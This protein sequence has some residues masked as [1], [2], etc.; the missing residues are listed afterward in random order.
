M[1]APRA[2]GI[3]PGAARLLRAERVGTVEIAHR[4]GAYLRVGPAGYLHVTGPRGAFGP[5]TVAV[6]GLP[7]LAPG[8]P[9]RAAG[10]MLDVGTVRI[11]VAGAQLRAIPPV[12]A[13]NRLSAVGDALAAAR[14]AVPPPSASLEPGIAGLAA[15]DPE[16]A[17]W[18]A[19]RGDGLTPAG[20]DVLAGFAAGLAATGRRLELTPPVERRAS[21]LGLAYLRCARRGEL[22]ERAGALL[23]AVVAGD[24]VAAARRA[25]LLATWGGSSGFALFWGMDVALAG[26]PAARPRPTR[27][28]AERNSLRSSSRCQ[29]AD[30]SWVP[31]TPS[32]SNRSIERAISPAM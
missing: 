21:P 23:R 1:T 15:G 31:N 22:P 29:S 20:D 28:A 2:V 3:G 4:R 11:A 16:A 7:C 8:W 12:S 5:L 13:S 32:R 17:G 26:W 25:R 30:C 27:H 6:A 19:G 9:V 18:L 10:R 14:A 24:P